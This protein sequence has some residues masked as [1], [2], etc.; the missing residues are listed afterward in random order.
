[1]RFLRLLRQTLRTGLE[2]YCP[3]FCRFFHIALYTYNKQNF[4]LKARILQLNDRRTLENKC[5]IN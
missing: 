3:R 2:P 1:M 4:K 5:Y